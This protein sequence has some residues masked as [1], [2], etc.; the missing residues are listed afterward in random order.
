MNKK[1]AGFTGALTDSGFARRTPKGVS[2]SC[3]AMGAH[4]RILGS[5]KSYHRVCVPFL[6]G[7]NLY[8][9]YCVMEELPM[10]AIGRL[11]LPSLIDQR[12]Q[13]LVA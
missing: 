8:V 6:L 9:N 3:P 4:G 11:F 5:P 1:G 10:N 7:L 13:Y 2:S 12:G